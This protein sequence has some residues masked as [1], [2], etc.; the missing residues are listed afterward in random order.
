MRVNVTANEQFMIAPLDLFDLLGPGRKPLAHT[1]DGVNSALV[2]SR[3]E[4]RHSAMDLSAWL[5]PGAVWRGVS[6]HFDD[7]RAE[8]YRVRDGVVSFRGRHGASS[9]HIDFRAD[10]MPPRA[11][12]V[13]R[14]HWDGTPEPF[15]LSNTA[16]AERVEY[17]KTVT[18]Q[19]VAGGE[20]GWCNDEPG[21]WESLSAEELPEGSRLMQAPGAPP[22]AL[23][24]C[25]SWVDDQGRPLDRCSLDGEGAL[26]ASFGLGGLYLEVPVTR[27]KTPMVYGY[28]GDAPA[29][30]TCPP[31]ESFPV[32]RCI[33]EY[34]PEA[35]ESVDD[36]L[37][38]H[39]DE[40]G[41]R[42]NLIRGHAEERCVTPLGRPFNYQGGSAPRTIESDQRLVAFGG[43]G[44]A[45]PDADALRGERERKADLAAQQAAADK[46]TKSDVSGEDVAR[47]RRAV[48]EWKSAQ[49][50]VFT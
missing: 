28:Y 30:T 44:Y 23:V 35:V 19:P 40:R 1:H 47:A 5:V 22:L 17:V 8:V 43:S 4:Q 39:A 25:G 24:N 50:V 36:G 27:T 6:Y 21:H 15:L 34:E 3:E 11:A 33:L 18:C 31:R 7:D 14:P 12:P 10:E 13:S 20:W 9:A 26:A 46:R 48:G 42:C 16:R 29:P 2:P 49:R 41:Y 45:L 32:S 37:C 38:P